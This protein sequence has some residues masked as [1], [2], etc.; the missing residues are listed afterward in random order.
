MFAR[1]LLYHEIPKYYTW[2]LSRRQFFRRKQRARVA[3]FVGVF[4]TETLGSVYTVHPNN[5]EC[6]FLRLLLHTVKGPTSF[7]VLRTVNDEICKTSY[8]QI[9]QKQNGWA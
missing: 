8:H 7:E 6:Y 4:A 5:A 9:K 1:T 2:N 3:D